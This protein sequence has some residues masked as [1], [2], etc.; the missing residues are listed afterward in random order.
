LLF[1]QNGN[2]K[3]AIRVSAIDNFSLDVALKHS[4]QRIGASTPGPK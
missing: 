1:S 2:A 4:P 3:P